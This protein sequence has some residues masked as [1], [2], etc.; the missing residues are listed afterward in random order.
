MGI[1]LCCI[2]VGIGIA[3]VYGA[4]REESCLILELECGTT[5]VQKRRRKAANQI[6]KLERNSR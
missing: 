5:Y 1:F 3:Y 2:N 6:D 4:T